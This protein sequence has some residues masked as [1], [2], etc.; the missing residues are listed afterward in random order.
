MMKRRNSVDLKRLHILRCLLH[1][2][3]D[4]VTQ[5]TNEPELISLAK[6]FNRGGYSISDEEWVSMTRSV[7][8]TELLQITG[9]P[10]CGNQRRLADPDLQQSGQDT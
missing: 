8:L 1:A 4:V 9:S 7:V 2:A 3:E 10:I 5:P 6:Q